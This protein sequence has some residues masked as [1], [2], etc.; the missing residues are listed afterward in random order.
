VFTTTRGGDGIPDA[1]PL[2]IAAEAF[3]FRLTFRRPSESPPASTLHTSPRP[4]PEP[5]PPPADTT[6]A[7]TCVKTVTEQPPESGAD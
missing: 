1:Q 2:R 6:P 7:P 5:T 3:S 4:G